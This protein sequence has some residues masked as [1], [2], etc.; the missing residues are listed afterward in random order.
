M[1]LQP[2]LKCICGSVTWAR[3]WLYKAASLIQCRSPP[4]EKSPTFTSSAGFMVDARNSADG[5]VPRRERRIGGFGPTRPLPNNDGKAMAMP[6]MP[7]ACVHRTAGDRLVR[8][9]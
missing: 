8:Q 5:A 9:P 4:D 7:S 6:L 1:L 2:K 3:E